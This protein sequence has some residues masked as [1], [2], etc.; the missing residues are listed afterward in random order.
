MPTLYLIATPIGNLEDI[1]QRGLRVLREV[2]LIAAEDTRVTRQL[3]SHY[4]IAKPLTTYTD[5]YDR[6]KASRQG[7]VLEALDAGQD[8]ALVS[9]AGTPGL[10][11]PGYELVQAVLAAGHAVQAIPGP[12]AIT[13]ALAASGLPADRFLFVGFLPRKAGERRSFLAEL[14]EEPGAVVAFEAPHRLVDALA[15]VLTVLGDRQVAVA[16]ELTKRFEEIWRGPVAGA[17]AYFTANPPR[18][19][20]TL[21]VAGAG[22]RRDHQRWPDAQLR[23]A[24]ELL[25]DEGL[26]PSSIARVLARLAGWPRSE[27]Y[28]L[29]TRQS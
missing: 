28:D 6:Q 21:V 13:T 24:I 23:V 14:A 2:A 26:A 19:E 9:D 4:A 17:L 18:G 5:A 10:S 25:A 11:D 15:D 27:V 1:S 22:R 29:V 8:V 7:R 16:R 20:I 12:S 3:L